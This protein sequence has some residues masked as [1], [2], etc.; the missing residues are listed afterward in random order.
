MSQ[1]EILTEEPQLR[2]GDHCC[3]LY[4]TAEQHKRF[5]TR[6]IRE[7]LALGQKVVCTVPCDG[8]CIV[9][10]YLAEVGVDVDPYKETHQLELPTPEMLYLPDGVFDP[11]HVVETILD[12]T[13]KA[14][15]EG[16][17]GLRG[18]GD[19]SWAMDDVPGHE[20][21]MEYECMLNSLVADAPVTAMCQYNQNEFSPGDLLEVIGAHPKVI[22]GD[23]IHENF[24]F[25]KVS[26]ILAADPVEA[27]LMQRM[28]S[29]LERTRYTQRADRNSDLIAAVINAV[30]VPLMVADREG[31]V[32]EFNYA[33]RQSLGVMAN[34]DDIRL[35]D[36]AEDANHAAK[37]EKAIAQMTPADLPDTF[38]AGFRSICNKDVR[39]QCTPRAILDDGEELAYIVVTARPIEEQQ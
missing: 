26:N 38:V 11:D 19:M 39:Y 12:L 31:H 28:N 2:P 22:Y 13:E 7:G 14:L 6:Y 27:A 1:A 33:F 35:S 15:D 8:P 23:N 30:T 3:W 21:L 4:E 32:F 10:E 24:Y 5:L 25:G 36:L 18:T 29:L 20:R 37:L 16:F 34:G 17:T 9:D